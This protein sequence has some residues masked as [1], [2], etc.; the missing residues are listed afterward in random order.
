MYVMFLKGGVR[1]LQRM[2]A[3]LNLKVISHSLTW[4]QERSLHNPSLKPRRQAEE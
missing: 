1:G 3:A 4:R 2:E